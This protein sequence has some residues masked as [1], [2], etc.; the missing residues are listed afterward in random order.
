MTISRSTIN[1]LKENYE[2]LHILE[3]LNAFYQIRSLVTQESEKHSCAIEEAFLDLHQRLFSFVQEHFQEEDF[4]SNSLKNLINVI[5]SDIHRI[6]NYT[7]S[8]LLTLYNTKKL[9]A[10]LDKE[11]FVSGKLPNKK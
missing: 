3:A 9:L 11:T 1:K 5:E 7:D 6:I 4:K 10:V 8:I 2:S